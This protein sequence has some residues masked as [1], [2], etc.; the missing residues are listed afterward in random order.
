MSGIIRIKV[1][2][3]IPGFLPGQIV[4]VPVDENGT[5]KVF[6]WRR[7]LRDARIDNCCEIVPEAKPEPPQRR[8]RRTT[9]GARLDDAPGSE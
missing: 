5:P 1:N 6:L 7:R 8:T 2:G 3:R 4:P 9:R